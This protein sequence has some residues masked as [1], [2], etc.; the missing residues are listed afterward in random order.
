MCIR[1]YTSNVINKQCVLITCHC[2]P[3]HVK[4]CTCF[5]NNCQQLPHTRWGVVACRIPLWRRGRVPTSS[6]TTKGVSKWV[7]MKH[8]KTHHGDARL[9]RPPFQRV[10][11]P[12]SLQ[13]G[14]IEHTKCLI[15]LTP[16]WTSY[17]NTHWEA[18]A[19]PRACWQ[20]IF[21][22]TQLWYTV[23]RRLQHIT[24]SAFPFS[25]F[26]FTGCAKQIL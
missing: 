26:P 20:Q 14:T 13:P 8:M 24:G 1:I 16:W 21:F 12:C 17:A 18:A 11:V 7:L 2:L 23:S 19:T 3:T 4:T 15:L 25:L 22:P 6:I 5:A 10:A 9:H